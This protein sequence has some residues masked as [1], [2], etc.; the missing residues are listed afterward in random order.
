[1]E[2]RGIDRQGVIPKVRRSVREQSKHQQKQE[3]HFIGY[4]MRRELRSWKT[5]VLR[6]NRDSNMEP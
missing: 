3:Q 4:T 2:M 1:M 5:P 6:P